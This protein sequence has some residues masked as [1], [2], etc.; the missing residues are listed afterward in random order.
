MGSQ[1][2]PPVSG[3]S[4][5]NKLTPLTLTVTLPPNIQFSVVLVKFQNNSKKK[6]SSVKTNWN[7]P[8]LFFSKKIWMPSS[9]PAFLRELQFWDRNTAR[10]TL[11]VL[12]SGIQAFIVQVPMMKMEEMFF[13]AEQNITSI[14]ALRR[15]KILSVWNRLRVSQCWLEWWSG[16][17]PPSCWSSSWCAYAVLGVRTIRRRNTWTTTKLSLTTTFPIFT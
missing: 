14:A 11:T 10:A 1:S 6:C 9:F 3:T 13:V 12:E 17:P 5:S 8:I 15:H 16:W 4:P 7:N 2:Q